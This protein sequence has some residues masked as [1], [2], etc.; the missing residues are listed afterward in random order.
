MIVTDYTSLMIVFIQGESTLWRDVSVHGVRELR[1]S[2]QIGNRA[3]IITWKYYL[4]NF[5]IK[6]ILT[7]SIILSCLSDRS[8]L[9]SS[10]AKTQWE[11]VE[12]IHYMS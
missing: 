9:E 10:P 8:C 5:K 4:L 12:K 6:Q 1:D 3:C 11:K 7:L 2:C